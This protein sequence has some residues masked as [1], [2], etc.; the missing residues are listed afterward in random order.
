MG[1]NGAKSLGEA[2]GSW[3]REMGSQEV[4]RGSL[5]GMEA[6]WLFR[7]LEGVGGGNSGTG[8]PEGEEC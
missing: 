5:G 2:T 1:R 4:G 3:A 6:D 8:E 7:A